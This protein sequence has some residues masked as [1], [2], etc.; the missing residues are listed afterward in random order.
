MPLDNLDDTAKRI[1]KAASERFLHYGYGKTTM[2]EIAA[3]CNMSTG[4]LYRYFP[5][6]LDIAETFARLLRKDQLAELRAVAEEPG[7]E[8][9]ERLRRL[10]KT[11]F[12][13]A[14]DRW[15]KKP[16]AYELTN[17]ILNE[18]PEFAVGWETAEGKII[19]GV[20][21]AGARAGVFYAAKDYERLAKIVQDAAFRFTSPALFHEGEFEVLSR[22]FDE[23]IALILDGLAHLRGP[24]QS[25]RGARELRA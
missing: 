7:L 23:V 5:S 3:D 19:A 10:L 1:L 11:K 17:E 22:E 12:R 24:D 21:E 16:K 6:K 13:L 8:P 14:Y 2:S 15:H 25:L 20:L 9:P 18:R 4:N